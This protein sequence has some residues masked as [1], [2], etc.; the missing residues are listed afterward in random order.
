M[1]QLYVAQQYL[2]KQV[3]CA[4][5][6]HSLLP[7]HAIVPCTQLLPTTASGGQLTAALLPAALN[8][9]TSYYI[10]DCPMA[11]SIDKTCVHNEDPDGVPLGP[12]AESTWLNVAPQ[13]FRCATALMG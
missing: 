4:A 13:G 12:R 3:P 6:L 8:H 2:V 1:V 9:Y 10:Q 5:M 11:D 7:H